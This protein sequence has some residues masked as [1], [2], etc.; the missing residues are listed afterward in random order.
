MKSNEA[1]TLETAQAKAA[2]ELTAA[3]QEVR[4]AQF[5]LD[6]FD[7]PVDFDG[8]TPSKAVDEMLVKLNQARADFEP[9]KTSANAA[10]PRPKPGKT[11]ALS[12]AQPR[13]KARASMMPGHV[14][15]KPFC[16]PNSNRL[17][18][19]RTRA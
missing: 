11:A 8:M 14:T 4:D 12:P 17:C 19:M 15:A 10:S 16:G 5:K 13:F 9:Y 1:Q 2:T 3:Y 6:N 18:K 7:V